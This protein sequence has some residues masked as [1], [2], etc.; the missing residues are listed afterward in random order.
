MY[1][2]SYV[3]N[4][5]K[6]KTWWYLWSQF[7]KSHLTSIEKT[8][9]ICTQNYSQ[10]FSLKWLPDFLPIFLHLPVCCINITF[11]IRKILVS[12]IITER[13]KFAFCSTPCPSRKGLNNV[14]YGFAFSSSL[15]RLSR[16]CVSPTAFM[17]LDCLHFCTFSSLRWQRS[18]LS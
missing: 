17:L 16:S 3:K 14:Q 10:W 2:Q 12:I 7:L 5:N 4:H 11:I 1:I 8:L 9:E 6:I 15:V 18:C 13:K